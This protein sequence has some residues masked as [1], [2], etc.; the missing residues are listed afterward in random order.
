MAYGNNNNSNNGSSTPVNSSNGISQETSD[1]VYNHPNENPRLADRYKGKEFKQYK[2]SVY[3]KLSNLLL[4]NLSTIKENFNVNSIESLQKTFRDGALR[5]G[6]SENELLVVQQVSTS[7]NISHEEQ[8]LFNWLDL[9]DLKQLDL[10]IDPEQVATDGS[11]LQPASIRLELPDKNTLILNDLIGTMDISEL[12]IMDRLSDFVKLKKGKTDVSREKLKE[13]IDVD[14]SELKPI[15]FTHLIEQYNNYKNKIPL[16]KYRADDFWREYSESID[17]PIAY[18][19]QRWFEEFERIKNSIPRGYL[20]D[21]ESLSS[22]LGEVSDKDL[23]GW[24]T[25]TY[26]VREA[27]DLI[28]TQNPIYSQD[29][30]RT[31]LNKI[32]NL[33]FDSGSLE[34]DRNYWRDLYNTTGATDIFKTPEPIFGCTDATALNFDSEADED[35]GSC[36]YNEDLFVDDSQILITAIGSGANNSQPSRLLFNNVQAYENTTEAGLNM[37][38]Y[39]QASLKNYIN[40]GQFPQPK[41]NSTY[42]TYSNI[43][44]D[45]MAQKILTGNWLMNDVF[46]ITSFES[47]GFN[48]LLIGALKSIGGCDPKVQN[49]LASEPQI[50][51]GDSRTPYVLIG[52]RGIGECGGSEAVGDDGIYSP[53][54]QVTINWF[55]DDDASGIVKSTGTA[56]QESLLESEFP[57]FEETFN[58]WND[59]YSPNDYWFRSI[60]GGQFTIGNVLKTD[61]PE[62]PS[63]GGIRLYRNSSAQPGYI[64]MPPTSQEFTDPEWINEE[65]REPRHVYLQEGRTYDVSIS[66][67][68]NSSTGTA[69]IE[70]GDRR[71]GFPYAWNVSETWNTNGEWKETNFQFTPNKNGSISTQWKVDFYYDENDDFGPS[72]DWPDSVP[73]VET[74]YRS[75]VNYDWNGELIEGIAKNNVRVRATTSIYAPVGGTYTFKIRHDD[76]ARMWVGNNQVINNWTQG[77]DRDTIGTMTLQ[78]NTI[79]QV[80]AEHYE[81]QSH[82]AFIIEWM[83]PNSNSYGLMPPAT[84]NQGAAANQDLPQYE[85]IMMN[86]YLYDAIGGSPGDYCDYSNLKIVPTTAVGAPPEGSI[87]GCTN[88]VATNYNQAA[89][90]DNGSCVF[91]TTTAVGCEAAGGTYT[92][93][94]TDGEYYTMGLPFAETFGCDYASYNSCIAGTDYF[95]NNSAC[96]NQAQYSNFTDAF[97]MGPFYNQNYSETFFTCDNLARKGGMARDIKKFRYGGEVVRTKPVPYNRRGPVVSSNEETYS[98]NNLLPKKTYGNTI[99]FDLPKQRTFTQSQIQKSSQLNPRV[100]TSYNNR[101]QKSCEYERNFLTSIQNLSLEHMKL[102]LEEYLKSNTP[103]LSVRPRIKQFHLGGQAGHNSANH[104]TQESCCHTVC[105]DVNGDSTVNVLD[106]VA[107][108][109]VVLGN[110]TASDEQFQC[111]DL[112]RD[113]LINV[114]DIVTIV[115]I[116]L[117]GSDNSNCNL[118][119]EIE[120]DICTGLIGCDGVCY[121]EWGGTPISGAGSVNLLPDFARYDVEGI[122]GGGIYNP[123]IYCSEWDYTSAGTCNP[124][125]YD[126]WSSVNAEVEINPD[127]NEMFVVP[128]DVQYNCNWDY[129]DEKCLS[130]LQEKGGKIRRRR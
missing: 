17:V 5:K 18:R 52:S 53:P 6:K 77:G 41:F 85:G 71:G 13:F 122:C 88:P 112:N 108:V 105:G 95:D 70:I 111:S 49:G 16:F 82:A 87:M 110:I 128:G 67:R 22:Y 3:N 92:Q 7:G 124:N 116:L 114:V 21:Y 46:I 23:F 55:F 79:Y 90:F 32:N 37:R 26:I 66:A 8:A 42:A 84:Q 31:W 115:Q 102:E 25:L 127:T 129:G 99:K 2:K 76:G 62:G 118:C 24:E 93:N 29:D 103:C 65:P 30:A 61:G 59:T 121:T 123:D 72:P 1:N 33:I 50:P 83:P 54:A 14:F 40:G 60:A 126:G 20:N 98:G 80:V 64:Y 97:C 117:D 86:V 113:G 28:G 9:S 91:D 12:E 57:A 4:K 48:D 130:S 94:Q 75:T 58:D 68:C 51:L 81:N 47:I 10:K 43:Q 106:V 19:V 11:I 73:L 34:N 78:A 74:Q 89:N 63:D 36:Q 45:A 125:Q 107:L 35:D 100:N 15:T 27:Q 69:G 120:P 119:T 96:A 39:S 56:Q 38:V 104:T 101:A 109:S 44:Q